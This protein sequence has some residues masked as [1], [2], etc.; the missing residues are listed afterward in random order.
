MDLGLVRAAREKKRAVQFGSRSAKMEQ[1][2]K[3]KGGDKLK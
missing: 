3:V 1:G 2:V